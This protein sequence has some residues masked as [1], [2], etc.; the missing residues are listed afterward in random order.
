M[1]IQRAAIEKLSDAFTIVTQIRQDQ[2]IDPL[3][4]PA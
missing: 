4:S 1:P 2:E 3:I